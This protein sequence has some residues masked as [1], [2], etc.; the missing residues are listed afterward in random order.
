MKYNRIYKAER[1]CIKIKAY[2]N[3]RSENHA[4]NLGENKAKAC[5][6]SF[7][8]E[9]LRDLKQRISVYRFALNYHFGDVFKD[10]L[11]VLIKHLE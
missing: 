5:V 1:I 6:F 3:G 4:C 9:N 7:F 11:S 10:K 2:K 8:I